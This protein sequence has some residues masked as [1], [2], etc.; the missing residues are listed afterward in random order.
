[1]ANNIYLP[2]CYLVPQV[3]DITAITQSYPMVV[4][5]EQANMYLAGQNLHF[6]VPNSYG[7]SQLDQMTGTIIEVSG[8]NF[9]V[10]I[11]STMFDP[12]VIPALGAE[13]PASVAPSGS[14]NVQYNNTTKWLPFQNINGNIGN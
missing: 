8:L 13:A 11:D 4:T 3:L 2:P 9:Y 7:M 1:M 10:N 6:S 5:V 12:F 14:K